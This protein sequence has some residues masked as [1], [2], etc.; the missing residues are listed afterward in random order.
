MRQRIVRTALVAGV[1]VLAMIL[2]LATCG[3][4]TGKPGAKARPSAAPKPSATRTGGPPT[5]LTVPSSYD[6]GR[7]WEVADASPEYAMAGL[8]TLGF[9]ER[10]DDFRFRLRAVDAA[11]G[12]TRWTGGPWQPLSTAGTYPRLLSVTREDKRFFVT[13]SYGKTP[14]EGPGGAS[15]GSTLVSLDLYDAEDG[16]TQRVEVPWSD[17]PTVTGSGPAVLITDG[18]S[19]SAVVDP[20]TGEVTTVEPAD[21]G[22]PKGCADCRRLT[23]VRAVTPKGLLVNGARE[24]WV[25]GGWTSRSGVP[26]GADPASG[27]PAAVAP[28]GRILAKWQEARGSKKAATHDIWAVHDPATGR[29]LVQVECRKPEVV[30]GDRPVALTSPQGRYLIAGNLA[31]D[32]E[33]GKG[34]CFEEPDGTRPLAL[35]TVTDE[36]LVYGASSART[37]GE[38]LAGGGSP[39]RVDLATGV[40][41]PLPANVRLPSADTAGVGLFRWTDPGDR[42]HLIAYARGSG[43]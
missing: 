18:K 38:A 23:E 3:G 15:G 33:N 5:Q 26:K 28:G 7:G 12:K 13:W 29:S 21:L 43:S 16:E 1:A 40:P 39:L 6:T 9:L 32:L 25:R 42:Q 17:A 31:F 10:V 14:G 8:D 36:G 41:E 34:W 22:Y 4:G 24:F 35:T 30:T 20:G 19:R 27:T 11:T 37:T 2:L